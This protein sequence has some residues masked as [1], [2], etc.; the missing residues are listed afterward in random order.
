MLLMLCI[1]YVMEMICTTIWI[2]Q[3][4][5]AIW[6]VKR[7]LIYA[8]KEVQTIIQTPL[9][10]EE[11]QL[12]YWFLLVSK[13][14]WLLIDQISLGVW[15]ILFKKHCNQ[16]LSD[17]PLFPY[18]LNTVSEK[19]EEISLHQTVYHYCNYHWW[20]FQHVL[21]NLNDILNL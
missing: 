15:T 2:K 14:S 1:N 13:I 21:Y 9:P 20:C 17:S 11:W 12:D 19:W 8:T 3:Y 5:P 4:Q 10:L 18:N 7:S 16:T 6:S